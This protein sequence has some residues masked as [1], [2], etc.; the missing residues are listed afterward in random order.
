VTIAAFENKKRI[1]FSSHPDASRTTV[2]GLL[3]SQF[4]DLET[5]KPR[6]NHRTSPFMR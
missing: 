4:L 5:V 6:Q 1:V 3:F 2:T